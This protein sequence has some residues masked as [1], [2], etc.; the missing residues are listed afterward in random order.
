MRD[1]KRESEQ[2]ASLQR[3][4]N[5]MNPFVEPHQPV[6]WRV[7]KAVLF[8]E[9]MAVVYLFFVAVLIDHFFRWLRGLP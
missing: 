1:L 3:V 9:G 4:M 8:W 5:A 2:L 7:T 6:W